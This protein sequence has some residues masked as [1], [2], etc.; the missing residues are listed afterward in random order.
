MNT[1]LDKILIPIDGTPIRDID[2]KLSIAEKE[3]ISIRDRYIMALEIVSFLTSL[4]I[5]EKSKVRK[6]VCNV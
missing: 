1:K 3:L 5:S 2:K 4:A 6:E